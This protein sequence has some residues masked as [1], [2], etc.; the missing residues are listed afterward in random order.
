[1]HANT[2]YTLVNAVVVHQIHYLWYREALHFDIVIEEF[3][4]GVLGMAG[5]VTDWG[6]PAPLLYHELFLCQSHL[7]NN[8]NKKIT[9]TNSIKKYS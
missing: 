2:Y 3:L 8:N 7:Y 4:G 6:H 1:M 9:L 5:Q